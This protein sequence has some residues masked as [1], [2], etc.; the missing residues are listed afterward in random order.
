MAPVMVL[1]GK[2]LVGA[3][4]AEEI[5]LPL[6]LCLDGAKRGMA[7][8]GMSNTITEHLLTAVVIWTRMNNRGLYDEAVA[9]WNALVKASARPTQLLDLTTGEYKAI[10]AA[11]AHFVRALPRVEVQLL[12]YASQ[13]AQD[14]LAK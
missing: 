1:I 10:R 5:E 2:Q 12:S 9:G 8:A 7:T 6:L 11:V 13:V 4:V 3:E 14:E